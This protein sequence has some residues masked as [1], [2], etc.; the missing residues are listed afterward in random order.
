MNDE[1]FVTLAVL[2]MLSWGEISASAESIPSR[3]TTVDVYV[4]LQAAEAKANQIGV[5]MGITVTD[6]HGDVRG[7]IKMDGTF[8]HAQDTSFSKAYT[9]VSL[10]QPTGTLPLAV[11]NELR[12]ITQ[13]RLTNLKGGVPITIN[14]IIIG[15]VGG[16]GG[17]G[18]EDEVVAQAG[19]EAVMKKKNR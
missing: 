17:V 11:A 4:A 19:A 12:A 10:R 13:G 7:F 2:A 14:G 18:N 1:F 9:A 5:P 15:G 8:V 3:L 16:G 6:A